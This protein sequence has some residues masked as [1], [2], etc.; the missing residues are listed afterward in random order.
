MRPQAVIAALL[1]AG[2]A[3]ASPMQDL[4]TA[5]KAFQTK[6]CEG[7]MP[8]LKNVLD[9]IVLSDRDDIFEAHAMLGACEV[10]T[11]QVDFAKQ[12]FRAALQLYPDK[13]LDPLYYST[14]ARDVYDEVKAKLA[15]EAKAA[16][17]ERERQRAKEELQKRLADLKIYESNLYF[18]NYLPF[19]A[20]Q[21]QNHERVRGTILLAGETATLGVSVGIWYY[22]VDKYGLQSSNVQLKDAQTVRTLQGVEIVSGAAFLALYAYG[23][24]DSL[25]NYQSKRLVPN[26]EELLKDL[27]KSTDKPKKTTL[28][29]GPI[30]VPGGAG[31]GVAWE[32]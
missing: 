24:Y 30:L 10:Q 2:T 8:Y 16:A 13:D 5:R 21:F 26:S 29:W 31:I 3:H 25:K 1:V 9:P 23:V 14:S 12:E 7:A 27:D 15:A 28:H 4:D 22:L 19:G 20:G 17:D 32:N 11:N 6:N 18:V